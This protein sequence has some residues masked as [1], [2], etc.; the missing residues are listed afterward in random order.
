MESKVNYTAVGLF[1]IVLAAALAGVAWWLAVGGHQ[2]ATQTYLIYATDNVN[3]LRTDSSVLYRGVAVGK[4]DAIGIDPRN[5]ALIRI[6]VEIDRDVPVRSDTVAQLSPLG[7]TGLSAVNLSGGASPEPLHP[8][9]GQT[10]P[11]I[12]YKPSLFTQ[13]EGGLNNAALTLTRIGDR[14]DNLLSPANVQSVA[15]SLH[16]L[17]ALT[18]TLADNQH[19]I[20]QVL[21]NA[22]LT[23]TRLA[24]TASGADK[25]VGQTR[26]LV[27]HI[28]ALTAQLGGVMPQLAS[29]ASSVQSAGASTTKFS[30]AGTDAMTDLRLR[31]LPQM[32]ALARSL[33]QL[34]QQLSDLTQ[35]LSA[36]PGQLLYG[37]TLPP[38][39]PG[40]A[41]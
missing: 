21:A 35:R 25:L 5:P 8:P 26:E 24:N 13:I 16:N 6:A 19:N 30:N 34:S 15:T 2:K 40:E 22:Q 9:P 23:S 11:V 3:G 29:A 32:D 18:Q 36:N 39:G 12:P 41:K 33:Q 27:S 38:P 31:T 14:I 17:Q 4:V 1:V 7:V 28:N 37:P 20:D 10:V